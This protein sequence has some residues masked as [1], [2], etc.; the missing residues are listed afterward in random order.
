MGSKLESRLVGIKLPGRGL[1]L[2]PF[3]ASEM[4]INICPGG[5]H[6]GRLITGPFGGNFDPSINTSTF[7]V[8]AS[9]QANAAR[10]GKEKHTR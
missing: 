3:L 2:H 4:G 5:Y 8:G 1:T 6:F 7:S 10:P 9:G